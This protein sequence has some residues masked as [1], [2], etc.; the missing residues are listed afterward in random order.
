MQTI[1]R[2]DEPGAAAA[3]RARLL[4]MIE[5]GVTHLVLAAALGGRSPQWPADEI[6]EPVIA[7]AR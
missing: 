3:T 6:I 5:A 4:E 1:V 7:E 2:C